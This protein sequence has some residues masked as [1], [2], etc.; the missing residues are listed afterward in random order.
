M[1]VK[2][3]SYLAKLEDEQRF[4]VH[5]PRLDVPTIKDLAEEVGIS[6]VQMQRIVS[7]NIDSLK[8][9]VGG[10]VIRVLRD[11]GFQTDV[12]DILEYRD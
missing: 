5:G 1:I 8:L 4:K 11:R 6:R 7:G 2:L 9:K 3:K 10:E 12:C